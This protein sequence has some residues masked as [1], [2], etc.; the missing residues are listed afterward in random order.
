[1]NDFIITYK[2]YNRTTLHEKK[3]PFKFNIDIFNLKT[4]SL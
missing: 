4:H 2:Y 1:M 3:I